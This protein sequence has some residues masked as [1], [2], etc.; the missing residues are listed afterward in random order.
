MIYRFALTYV[1]C[2]YAY[3][4]DTIL[5]HHLSLLF[6]FYRCPPLLSPS[7]RLANRPL[8][9]PLHT[10]GTTC[11]RLLLPRVGGDHEICKGMFCCYQHEETLAMGF[12]PLYSTR[13]CVEVYDAV[14]DGASATHL[15]ICSSIHF[16]MSR[17]IDRACP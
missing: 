3:F 12:D 13:R 7:P 9:L 11:G 4:A 1:G 2:L 5:S 15:S 8:F 17:T 16:V 14:V 6:Y 10:L